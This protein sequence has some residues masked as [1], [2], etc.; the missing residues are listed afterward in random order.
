MFTQRSSLRLADGWHKLKGWRGSYVRDLMGHHL[1]IFH[2]KTPSDPNWYE[3]M[4][5]YFK[6]CAAKLREAKLQLEKEAKGGGAV[7]GNKLDGADTL[8]SAANDSTRS[9]IGC[10]PIGAST[11]C[12][13]VRVGTTLSFVEGPSSVGGVMGGV[14][15]STSA[16]KNEGEADEATF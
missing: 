8:A 2:G 6:G 12:M 15:P 14:M 9:T 13:F 3:W 5:G 10:S 16:E 1:V 7:W 4:D 11:L